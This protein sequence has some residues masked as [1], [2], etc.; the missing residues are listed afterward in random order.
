VHAIREELVDDE[1]E[2]ARGIIHS[3]PASL[4][5][6]LQRKGEG[7]C[8]N[9]HDLAFLEIFP[10]RDI[11]LKQSRFGISPSLPSRALSRFGIIWS[12]LANTVSNKGGEEGGNGTETF[13]S[14]LSIF[15][16]TT[17]PLVNSFPHRRYHL[18]ARNPRHSRKPHT[19]SC[20]HAAAMYPPLRERPKKG[21]QIEAATKMRECA[22]ARVRVLSP[23]ADG[24]RRDERGGEKKPTNRRVLLFLDDALENAMFLGPPGFPARPFAWQTT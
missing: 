24:S 4:I 11:R 18:S 1:E 21:A 5:S 13:L 2:P 19:R 12:S 9:D 16:P 22:S 3:R 20:A 7:L 6:S 10:H 8:R 14:Q 23:V 15:R 17:V